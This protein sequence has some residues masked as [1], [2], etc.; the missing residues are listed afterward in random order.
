MIQSQLFKQKASS[1]LKEAK[2]VVIV[3]FPANSPHISS[4]QDREKE[5]ENW[6]KLQKRG[7]A[8]ESCRRD[9]GRSTEIGCQKQISNHLRRLLLRAMVVSTRG[10]SGND[11]A[12]YGLRITVDAS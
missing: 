9:G 7:C 5:L 11:L 1:Y 2:A 12:R 3:H 4:I 6:V 8:V 10:K